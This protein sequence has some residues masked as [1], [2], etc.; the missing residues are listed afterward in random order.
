MQDVRLE[1]ISAIIAERMAK[2][3]NYRKNCRYC[4][5]VKNSPVDLCFCSVGCGIKEILMVMQC[6]QDCEDFEEDM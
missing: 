1:N 2:R 4:V 6:S 5:T 3:N